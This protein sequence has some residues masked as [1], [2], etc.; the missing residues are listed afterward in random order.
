MQGDGKTGLHS[1]RE[2]QTFGFMDQQGGDRI[3]TVLGK[4]KIEVPCLTWLQGDMKN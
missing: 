3:T 1:H 4:N 2:M